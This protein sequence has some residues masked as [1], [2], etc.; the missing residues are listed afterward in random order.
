MSWPRTRILLATR[1][2]KGTGKKKKE[3]EKPRRCVIRLK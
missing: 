3:K 2:K 1:G